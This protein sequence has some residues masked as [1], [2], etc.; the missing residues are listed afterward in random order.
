MW[1]NEFY[2]HPAPLALRTDNIDFN[3][4]LFAYSSVTWQSVSAKVPEPWAPFSMLHILFFLTTGSSLLSFSWA[5]IAFWV[6]NPGAFK[7]TPDVPKRSIVLYSILAALSIWHNVVGIS[8][9]RRYQG[10]AYTVIMTSANF[11]LILI[12]ASVLLEEDSMRGPL[13]GR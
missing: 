13:A 9:G 7:G 1:E 8:Y 2:K 6:W 5:T 11:A 4:L 12:L 10:K 3:D